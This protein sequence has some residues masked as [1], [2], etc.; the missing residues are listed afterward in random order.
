MREQ[1]YYV[2]KKGDD[3]LTQT[4]IAEKTGLSKTTVNRAI[5]SMLQHGLLKD[6]DGYYHLV[7]KYAGRD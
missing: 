6:I 4:D 2:C 3:R 5:K 7:W 1:H